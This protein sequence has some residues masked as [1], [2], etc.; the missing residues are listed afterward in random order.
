MKK[1]ILLFL[2]ATTIAF[3]QTTTELSNILA[4]SQKPLLV[5]GAGSQLALSQNIILA[6]AGTTFFDCAGTNT[7]GYNQVH[8]TI[9]PAS[10]T[11]TAGVVTF[12][13]SND[14]FV[15]FT[16]LQLYDIASQTANPISSY[17]IVASTTRY[18]SGTIH[19][20]YVRARISTA[21]TGTTTGLQAF[22][23]FKGGN[24]VTNNYNVSQSTAA[25]LQTTATIANTVSTN[26][27]SNPANTTTG[28]SGVKTGTF[29]G[30]TVTN[31]SSK[32]A[33]ILFNI[34]VVSGTTPT[35]VAKLQ[36]SG[37]NGSTW[38]DIPN[39]TTAT[40]TATGVF[41]IM[42]YPSVTVFAGTTVTGTTAVINSVLPRVWRVVY[43]ITGTT[44]SFSLTNVQ[45]QYIL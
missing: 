44:P 36:A 9:V 42:V 31:T 39:A 17:T 6:T 30:A 38:V 15:T 32:G 27:V 41:G 16:P 14:N 4:S 29:N 22:S 21:I 2:F 8:F 18:L 13:E 43:T 19:Y 40:L 23:L 1:L 24:F 11:V 37:D 7:I 26:P 45:I 12:E 33:Y 10:G 5:T 20:R 3:S 34:G 35:M 25:N 28:D